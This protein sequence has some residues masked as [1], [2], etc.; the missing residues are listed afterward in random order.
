[1]LRKVFVENLPKNKT[2]IN[3]DKINWKQCI[4]L[5]IKVIYGEFRGYVLIDAYDSKLKK[6]TIKYNNKEQVIDIHQFKQGYF[7]KLLECKTR[8]EN[9]LIYKYNLGDIIEV[10][11]GKI[12][13]INYDKV[14]RKDYTEKIYIYK[15]L[16]DGYI[17]HVTESKLKIKNGCP[18]CCNRLIIK[19]INDIAT[20]HSYLLDLFVDKNQAYSNSF[21]SNNEVKIKCTNCGYE[22]EMSINKL[23]NRGFSCPKC[24]D[25]T[26]Y[27]EKFM[28]NVLEQLNIDFEIQKTFDWSNGRQYDFYIKLL[29][30]IIETHGLQ[31]YRNSYSF[32]Y[33]IKLENIQA[34]DKYKYEL[35]IQNNIKRYI[36]IDC[37]KW[38]NDWIK[39]HILNSKL[40]EI[41]DLSNIN[42]VE[43]HRFA[44]HSRV[45]EI[46]NLWNGDYSYMDIICK[47]TKLSRLTV[48]KYLKQGT[49]LGW[50]NY[51]AKKNM[52]ESCRHNSK[53][54]QIPIAMFDKENKILGIFQ[55]ATELSKISVE[56]FGIKL[57]QTAI[58]A[59][60]RGKIPHHKG[61]IFKFI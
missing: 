28:F 25:G 45:K 10:S 19:G 15:C 21:G 47:K 5:N 58:S 57:S 39:Y 12:E 31:H 46:C 29:K 44:C 48:I 32:T 51:N 20:T 23:I 61:F 7:G 56:I 6:L 3:K 16:K 30:T 35:A 38:N 42:W 52:E 37:R 26:S 4:G 9:K 36:I 33:K 59:V 1:M 11:T 18:V 13:I 27:A 14:K 34:N 60:C 22:K 41:F 55:S 54:M 43:C 17:G 49:K 8:E 53:R 2:G 24:G 40:A 50:C